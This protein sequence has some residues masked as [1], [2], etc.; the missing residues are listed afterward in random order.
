VFGCDV[1]V[2]IDMEDMTKLEAKSEKCTFIGYGGDYF[3]YKCW[4]IKEKKIIQ[5]RDM[6]FN[7]KVMYKQQLQE[8]MEEFKK[9]YAVVEDL[10]DGKVTHESIQEFT[11]Q[12]PQTPILR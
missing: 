10:M 6:E 1:F 2:H 5:S 9:E 4:S 11:L 8:N 7:E 12:E 3:T